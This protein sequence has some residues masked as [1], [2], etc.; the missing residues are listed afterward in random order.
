M[1]LGKYM[2]NYQRKTPLYSL[3]ASDENSDDDT[4][5]IVFGMEEAYRLRV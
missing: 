5:F 3:V 1:N 4:L 2:R